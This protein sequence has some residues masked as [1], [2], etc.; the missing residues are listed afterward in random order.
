MGGDLAINVVP[1]VCTI[2]SKRRDRAIH[3]IEQDADLGRVNDI[4]CG[5]RR[6]CDLSGV[7]VYSDVQ[8][9]P[10]ALGLHAVLLKQLFAG[11]VNLQPRAIY[12]QVHRIGARPR[13]NHVQA[14]RTVAQGCMIPHGEIKTEQSDDSTDQP[15]GLPQG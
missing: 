10:R 2:G 9:A 15:F 7:G 4:A 6:R 1:V 13:L 14:L 5:Q 3:L 8:L 11:A 12:Q